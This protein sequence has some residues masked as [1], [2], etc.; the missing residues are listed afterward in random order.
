[1]C[2]KCGKAFTPDEQ[3]GDKKHQCRMSSELDNNPDSLTSSLPLEATEMSDV[4]DVFAVFADD[5]DIIDE[6]PSQSFEVQAMEILR[7]EQI[8]IQMGELLSERKKAIDAKREALALDMQQEGCDA[9]KYE[10]GLHPVRIMKTDV[11]CDAKKKP[12][13]VDWFREHGYKSI[14]K[15]NIEF[16]PE[17]FKAAGVDPMQFLQYLDNQG[18]TEFV[19]DSVHFQTMGA[20]IK[21]HIEKVETAMEECKKTGKQLPDD[22]PIA[23]PDSIFKICT[24][25]SVTIR[26][27]KKWNEGHS[28]Q[29]RVEAF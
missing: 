21:E 7:E 26:G 2:T 28:V 24:R 16:N 25:P 29:V 8:C 15:T 12:Q 14:I 4:L 13:M 5:T 9:K 1:M 3:Y 27:K 17:A 6:P 20:T 22:A 23:V 11:Y 18:L 10:S 19:K